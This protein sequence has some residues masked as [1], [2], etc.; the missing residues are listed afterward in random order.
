[1]PLSPLHHIF[2]TGAS[3]F[4]G[5]HILSQLLQ[6]SSTLVCAARAK[7]DQV[8]SDSAIVPDIT[9]PGPFGRALE[10]AD[11]PPFDTVVHTASPFVFSKVSS[12][13]EFLDPAV[14]GTTEI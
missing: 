8:R 13:M 2:L 11:P 14:K 12:N 6:G 1:M 4:I 5:S 3:G 7:A 10:T 9:A